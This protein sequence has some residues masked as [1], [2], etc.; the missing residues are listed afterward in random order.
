[1]ALADVA[2]VLGGEQVL[3]QPLHHRLDLI[4]LG[5]K[6]IPKVALVHLAHFLSCSLHD[7]VALL[8][9]TERTLQRY[10]PRATIEPY[11]LRT[12]FAA[13]GSGG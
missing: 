5:R 10:T 9:V 12:Y 13:G 11:G 1:M 4:T 2:E 6:G 3:R 7:L 8:P